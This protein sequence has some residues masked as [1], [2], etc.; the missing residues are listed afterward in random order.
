LEA[1]W[2]GTA[3]SSSLGVGMCGINGAIVYERIRL[4]L[5]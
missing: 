5:Y 3:G 4:D 1:G 2:L